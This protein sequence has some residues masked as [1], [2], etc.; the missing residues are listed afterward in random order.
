MSIVLARE[1]ADFPTRAGNVQDVPARSPRADATDP[2]RR[3]FAASSRCRHH[4]ASRSADGRR[5]CRARPT[6]RSTRSPAR[7]ADGRSPPRAASKGCPARGQLGLRRRPKRRLGGQPRTVSDEHRVRAGRLAA[8]A[9]ALIRG[10]RAVRLRRLVLIAT[11]PIAA[12]RR[13][14]GRHR[15][16][17][18]PAADRRARR[19]HRASAPGQ[20]PQPLDPDPRRSPGGR[21]GRRTPAERSRD[22]RGPLS[23]RSTAPHGWGHS[24]PVRSTHGHR[25]GRSRAARRDGYRAVARRRVAAEDR[26]L[27]SLAEASASGRARDDLGSRRDGHCTRLPAAGLPAHTP[28]PPRPTA[29]RPSPMGWTRQACRAAPPFARSHHRG[30]CGQELL[31]R[32]ARILQRGLRR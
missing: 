4:G 15:R 7:S 22:R 11:A 8:G 9:L 25:T 3:E 23:V 13:R 27:R 24:G 12:A 32:L 6:T 20:D 17:R 31:T 2:R 16:G 19:H 5:S 28:L 29:P 1:T 18:E 26:R 10:P 14:S 21:R 30:W